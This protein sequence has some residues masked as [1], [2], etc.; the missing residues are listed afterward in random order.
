MNCI[1]LIFSLSDAILLRVIFFCFFF[2]LSFH[3]KV[4]TMGV[5]RISFL[6]FFHSGTCKCDDWWGCI[7]AKTIL[8]EDRVQPYR[9]SECSLEDYRNALQ[10]GH[11][12][13]L[14]N[15]PNES[16]DFRS[17]GNGEIDDDEECDCGSHQE[18]L[19]RDPCCD[20][21]TCKFRQEAQCST[22]SCCDNCK[23]SEIYYNFPYY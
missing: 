5:F 19:E 2:F 4:L 21:N 22:G 3:L 12:F 18:C 16:K 15:K 20:P 14:L 6:L 1:Q 8:N 9:F 13:C 10:N 17:C 11:G 23:A 7:M